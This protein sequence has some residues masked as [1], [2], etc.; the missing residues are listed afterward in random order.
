MF[1]SEKSIRI[2]RGGWKMFQIA[3]SIVVGINM[4]WAEFLSKI[5]KYS[6]TFTSE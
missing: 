3:I 4:P 6:K 5:N 1:F 2:K